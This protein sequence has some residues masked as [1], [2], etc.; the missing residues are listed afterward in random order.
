MELF[1][2]ATASFIARAIRLTG[3]GQG[4]SLPG[5]VTNALFPGFLHAHAQTLSDGVAIVTGTNGK[6][7]TANMAARVLRD[8]GRDF[9]HNAEGA[10]LLSGIASAF[11]RR[12]HARFALLEIDEA[13]VPPAVERLGAPRVVTLINLFRDQLDRYGEVDRLADGW[14]AALRDL[15]GTMLVANADDPLVTHVALE[16]GLPTVFFGVEIEG[17]GPSSEVSDVTVCPRCTT[18]LSYTSR[19]LSQLGDYS[20]ASCGFAR[21][22]RDLW[23]SAPRATATG[24]EATLGGPLGDGTLALRVPGLHNVYNAL[25]ALAT[26]RELGIDLDLAIPSLARYQPVFGR[27][28]LVRRGETTVQVNLVKNP[29]GMNQTLRALRDVPGDKALVF[30][31]NDNIADGRDISW[32][33]DVDMEELLPD[34]DV[35]V[36]V[37]TRRREMALRLDY[38]GVQGDRLVTA[39][40]VGEALGLLAQRGADADLPSAHLHRAARGAR[41]AGGL[42][43]GGAVSGPAS[44]AIIRLDAVHLYPATMNTYG[45]RGNVASLTRRASARNI[46]ID[47]A[48]R[49][50]RR[51]ASGALRPGVHGRRAGPHT[52]RGRRRPAAREALARASR[53]RRVGRLRGLRRVAASGPSLHRRGRERADRHRTARSRDGGRTTRRVAAHRQR[54]RRRGAVLRRRQCRRRRIPARRDAPARRLREPRWAHLAERRRR[55]LG[56]VRIGFGNNGVD[57]GEGARHGTVMATYLH[58]PVLPKNA[59]LTDELLALA[60][61]HAGG[62]ALV[63]LAHEREDAAQAEAVLIAERDAARAAS[64]K[65]HWREPLARLRRSLR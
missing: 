14:L 11:A 6:T 32:I 25:G 17:G 51:R 58:G 47:L 34:A 49:R 62:G 10:N 29:A 40:S 30:V 43:G 5:K 38:A 65:H 13:I 28:S 35:V 12:P 37:G 41:H 45:D 56:R 64:E 59:W 7:T 18:M 8:A 15:D 19:W 44:D 33:W 60:V 63:P 57:G 31:L 48:H 3:A 16:S 39:A 26:T 55:P 24:I 36:T 23:A 50:A 4:S 21:P 20:C 61:A 1:P 22:A 27:W 42:G 52:A 2:R 53:R 54:G 9:V 46:E